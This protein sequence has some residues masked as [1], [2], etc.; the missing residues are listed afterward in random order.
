MKRYSTL[1][2]IGKMQIK[3]TVSYHLTSVSMAFIKKS[4]NAGGGLKKKEPSYTL[5]KNV[6]WCSLHGKQNGVSLKK[7]KIELLYDP[8]NPLIG[9]YLEKTN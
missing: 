1:P 3:S 5:A 7:L 9:I 2:V 6:Y 4:A 8:T